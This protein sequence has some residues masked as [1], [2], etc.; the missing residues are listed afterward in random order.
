MLSRAWWRL[1]AADHRLGRP[2]IRVDT[3]GEHGRGWDVVD[4]FGG[5]RVGA[6]AG[7]NSA[8]RR[9]DYDRQPVPGT[10]TSSWI[11]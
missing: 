9:A 8:D 11:R 1:A 7:H 4:P 6:A 2:A 10:T 3:K 5:R